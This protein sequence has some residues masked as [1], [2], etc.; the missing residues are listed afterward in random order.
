[1][2]K[3]ETSR[4]SAVFQDQEMKTSDDRAE[5][6][7]DLLRDERYLELTA[8]LKKETPQTIVA[9]CRLVAKYENVEQLSFIKN[10]LSATPEV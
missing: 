8:S 5:H 6:Y 7:L 2:D 4:I 10:L 3:K 1:M 9:F